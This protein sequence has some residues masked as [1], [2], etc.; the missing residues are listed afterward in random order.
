MRT[1]P[2][3]ARLRAS[4]RR[5][6]RALRPAGPDPEIPQPITP[7][8]QST[9]ARLAKIEQQLSNQN[10]LLLLGVVGILGDAL[11]KVLTK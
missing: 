1:R 4:L 11:Y 10:R 6:G 3:S 2:A 7:W 8:E 9:D 5:F